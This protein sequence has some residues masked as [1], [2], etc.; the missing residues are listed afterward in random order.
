MDSPE[1]QCMRSV[2]RVTDEIKVRQK[3]DARE[4]S[5]DDVDLFEVYIAP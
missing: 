2:R 1:M 3:A 4:V 5:S